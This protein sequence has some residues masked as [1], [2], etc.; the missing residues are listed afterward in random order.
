MGVLYYSSRPSQLQLTHDSFDIVNDRSSVSFSF[1]SRSACQSR[2]A[3]SLCHSFLLVICNIGQIR[4]ASHH[5]R[6]LPVVEDRLK[7][8][9]E[10]KTSKTN[11]NNNLVLP[12]GANASRRSLSCDVGTRA[13]DDINVGTIHH[14]RLRARNLSLGSLSAGATADIDTESLTKSPFR[15]ENQTRFQRVPLREYVKDRQ[16]AESRRDK[17][18]SLI[19]SF[20]DNLN[21]ADVP[22]PPSPTI[23][24]LVDRPKGR[25]QSVTSIA[26]SVI[27]RQRDDSDD[28]TKQGS[29]QFKRAM[30]CTQN[31]RISM[32][33]HDA[34]GKVPGSLAELNDRTS[35]F[36][37]S[38]EDCAIKYR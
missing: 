19:C 22:L 21:A 15:V 18:K 7:P 23:V 12:V 27:K 9:E 32:Q 11:S 6:S 25:Q 38:R 30:T 3:S 16:I 28:D 13:F 26:G 31:V 14:S 17:Q 36:D 4:K 33:L 2:A 29:V 37:T 5:Q 1:D 8:F 24:P 20:E 10:G 34:Y 35:A